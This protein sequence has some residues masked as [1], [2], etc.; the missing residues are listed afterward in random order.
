MGKQGELDLTDRG[1]HGGRR[2]GAG[3]K[4]NKAKGLRT[5]VSHG[6]REIVSRHQPLHITLRVTDAVGRLRRMDTYRA[7]RRAMFAMIPRTEVFRICQVSLQSNH[8]HMIVEANDRDAL[9][10]GMT[11]FET[12]MARRV[13]AALG[14]RRGKV[15]ADRF[16]AEILRS[17]R[18]TRNALGYLFN[19]WRKHRE[20]R[21]S[22][23]TLDPFA[24]GRT[25]DGF[26][27]H[28][29]LHPWTAK[30]EPLPVAF[31]TSWMLTTG[32]KR[33]GL[34]SVNDVPGPRA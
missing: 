13:N 5:R 34:L 29:T 20:D 12:S 28:R 14:R 6:A 7:V 10:R 9:T 21:G 27:E 2:K 18:Q 19:N 23:L 17:P 24:T 22:A 26:V 1:R 33:G 31:A 8:V 16:H 3:R 32:W 30:A 4:S 25:F 11:S 15:F